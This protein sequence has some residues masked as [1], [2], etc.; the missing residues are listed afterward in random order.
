MTGALWDGEWARV[1]REAR[2]EICRLL[3]GE[4]PG[5]PIVYLT[6]IEMLATVLARI[7][8]DNNGRQPCHNET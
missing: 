1:A 4:P 2:A 6:T 8:A 5:D 7:D 3:D